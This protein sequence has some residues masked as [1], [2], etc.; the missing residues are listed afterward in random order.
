M[1]LFCPFSTGKKAKLMTGL[2]IRIHKFCLV[3][4]MLENELPT[5]VTE[6]ELVSLS[7]KFVKWA[8]EN[9]EFLTEDSI[10]YFIKLLPILL[11][12]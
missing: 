12:V 10:R 5:E 6:K 8:K 2:H 9:N 11:T 7:K 3:F 4:D 1:V